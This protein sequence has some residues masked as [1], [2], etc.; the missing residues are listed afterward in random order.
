MGPIHARAKVILER[1]AAR[2]TRRL[3]L[4][5]AAGRAHYP[6]ARGTLCECDDD[7]AI[8]RSNDPR[9]VHGTRALQRNSNPASMRD[10][11]QMQCIFGEPIDQFCVGH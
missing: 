10:D 9:H 6:V 1:H 7:R 4:L 11:L 5:P 8:I 2:R 3:Y